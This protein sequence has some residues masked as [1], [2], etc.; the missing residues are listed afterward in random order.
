M[1]EE[2]KHAICSA[3][4]SNMWLHCPPSARRNSEVTDSGSTYAEEGS[5]AHQLCEYKLKKLLGH[6][7]RNPTKRLSYYTAE[8]ERGADD[9]A[10]FVSE[11]IAAA[12]ETCPDPYVVV[13]QRVDFSDYVEDGF[14]T[15]DCIIIG[16]PTLR[17][18]DF[19]FGA[20]T[21]VSAEGEDGLGNSQ[22]MLYALGALAAYG[23]LFDI[24]T[25]SMSIVQPRR[26]NISTFEMS[27]S[28]LYHWAEATLKPAAELAYKGEGEYASGAWCKFCRVKAECRARADYA[29]AL[30]QLDFKQPPMLEDFEVEYVLERIETLVSWANDI[31]EFALVAAIGG[32]KWNG[33][34]LV[35][36][37]SNRR[38]TDENAVAEVIRGIG[39]DPYEHKVLGI[40]AMTSLLGRKRFEDTLAEFIEKPQGK[41]VLVP[42][43]DKRQELNTNTAADDFADPIEN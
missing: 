20:G 1:T 33:W 6:P 35:E 28:E 43:T 2:K 5:Q 22:L 39:L 18:I 42:A 30:A 40:T 31:K 10:T 41:P 27:V 15:A 29:M 17:I 8:M 37:R 21:A 13:E 4:S 23:S 9:Y 7:S 25:V 19:K 26:D 34:K 14:G 11:Q 12:K 36:G 24:E 16:E 32:K 3:S 38:Y